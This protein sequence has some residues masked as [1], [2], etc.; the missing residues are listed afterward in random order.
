MPSTTEDIAAPPRELPKRISAPIAFG[1][2]LQPLNS[3]MIAVALVGIRAHFHAGAEA[4]W[5]VSALYLATAVAAPAMGRLADMLGPR[6]VSLAGLVLV[7]LASAAAP[8]ASSVAVL[9]VCR[10][11][12]GIGTAAQ[13]PCGVAMIRHAADRVRAAANH[14]LATLAVSSQ[15]SVAL[16]PTLGGLLV[17]LFGWAGIFWV[18]VPL[19]LVAAAAIVVWGPADPPAGPGTA[20]GPR[21]V[22][23][24]LDVPG[25]TLFVVAVGALMFWLL[26][27]SQTPAWWWLAV[28][29]PAAALMVAWSLRAREPFLDV[30]LL[31]ARALSFT[32]VRT[33]ATYTAFYALFYGLPQWLE[34]VRGLGPTGAGLVVLP[35]AAL[36]VVSTLL[37]T[38]LQRRR[39]IRASLVVGTAALAVGGLLLTLPGVSTPVPVL[40]LICAVLGLPNGFNNMANQTAVYAAAPAGHMGSA[41]GLYRT[42]QYV[43]ANFAAAALALLTGARIDDAG[44]HR[45]GMTVAAIS[46]ALL[47]ATLAGRRTA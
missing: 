31:A 43:G 30:R 25:M 19:V 32:Y 8:F 1:T 15:V 13:Y 45:V 33:L 42:F 3:S 23:A 40:L 5:L 46:V 24:R 37:A 27:L 2:I 34:E 47:I 6:R 20:L 21:T 9:V 18:N 16:G 44:L 11:L 39:G 38:R 26:S 14:A 4:A 17:G 41:S 29:V 36:G 7:G 28:S 10:V 22:L 12:I 35:I